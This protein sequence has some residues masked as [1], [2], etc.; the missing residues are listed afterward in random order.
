MS[1]V[2]ER[3]E[4]A[5]DVTGWRY[6]AFLSY[7]HKL[8]GAVAVALQHGVERF[9]KPWY[10]VRSLRV[11]RD[12]AN[13]VANA[14]LWSSIE[15]ALSSS[16]WF[17]LMASPA[18][19]ASPWVGREVTWWL[20]HRSADRL[21]VVLTEGEF[22]YADDPAAALP[23][24][25]RG[26]FPEEPRWVD[27][28]W[29]RD[30]A[31]VD[32]SNPRLRECV[33][34]V[35]AAVREVPKDLVVGEH[36][37]EHRRTM[38]LARGGVLTLALLLVGALVAAYL[39]VQRGDAAVAAQRTSLTRGLVAQ[40]DAVRDRDPR[41]AL[42]FGLAADSLDPSPL[43]RASLTESLLNSPYRATLPASAAVDAVAALPDG[44]TLAAGVRDGT[45]QFWDIADRARP[46]P[47]GVTAPP[48]DARVNVILFGTDGKT[49]IT[50]HD[51]GIL[52]LW[53]ITTPAAPRPIGP[54][55]REHR[56]RIVT[57]A[58]SA[59]GRN[60]ASGSQDGTVVLW[61]LTDPAGP[62]PGGRLDARLWVAGLRFSADG[63]TLTVA[64]AADG[65]SVSRWDVTDPTRPG[66]LGRVGVG[67]ASV[68]AK[69]AFSPDGRTMAVGDTFGPVML[70]DVAGT[71]PPA[72]GTALPG[73]DGTVT[74]LAFSAD[75]SSLVAGTS[76]RDLVVWT[77]TGQEPSAARGAPLRGHGDWI[78]AVA[79]LADG[80]NL[81]SA[82]SDRSVV[83]WDLD[84]S[85]PASPIGDPLPT[86]DDG[87]RA[88]TQ[89]GDGH[90]TAAVSADSVVLWDLGDPWRPR[91]LG[92][93]IAGSGAALSRDGRTMA[94]PDGDGET[95][96]LWDL[97]DPARP[98]RL[99]APIDMFGP[100]VAIS[101]D[102]TVLATG[103]DEGKVAL[104]NISDRTRPRRLELAQAGDSTLVTAL[105]FS[106]DGTRLAVGNGDPASLDRSTSQLWDLSDVAHPRRAELPLEG[107]TA[108]FVSEVRFSPDDQILALA[109][110]E[111]TVLLWDVRD[112]VRPQ[113]LGQ[114]LV[115]DSAESVAFSPDGSMLATADRG[116]TV[117]L[118][119][120]TDRTRIRRMGTRLVGTR[121]VAFAPDG[122]TLLTG[123]RWEENAIRQWDL[124]PL[125]ELRHAASR[126]ACARA[127]AALD[128]GTWAFLAPGVDY[129]DPCAG[130]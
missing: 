75:G 54:R 61:D 70:W 73:L 14:G 128:P 13:L 8:D 65:I 15:E 46:A 58:L 19:A 4:P 45:V 28:R 113:L 95:C 89:A 48:L 96:T 104:W 130:Q 18:A 20:T 97:T 85:P 83:L 109:G 107:R 94:A 102:G 79:F 111:D 60:L 74:A 108:L 26:A 23:S 35:A 81:A 22:A 5:Q 77:V 32:Q 115:H 68:T 42:Q 2:R 40:A 120:M 56:D 43:T 31:Q 90:L 11:F 37:R 122:R 123:T 50:A 78:T 98:R 100:A 105:A 67:D 44:R 76:D 125:N 86:Q 121:P 117:V 55:M 21:L 57:L 38:R 91:R 106:G 93:P 59:D 3:D 114:P 36:I 101:P 116:D 110:V 17:V 25:L 52:Q 66:L 24:A 49:M 51:S 39:A 7:S 34:D 119:D 29:L 62:R 127:G 126:A 41:R 33:A 72:E 82:S 99:S 1:V 92:E 27:L 63:R 124:A 88:I 118:W 112:P 47:V 69:V 9:A 16:R 12:D 64:A 84:G 53:D 30:L 10:R 87:V 71:E 6:D 129:L 80:H 103:A